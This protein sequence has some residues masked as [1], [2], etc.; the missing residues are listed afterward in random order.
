[1]SKIKESLQKDLATF[2]T[3]DKTEKLHF[4]WD[5][6]KIPLFVIG[7]LLLILVTQLVYSMGKG[8][9]AV[10]V[11]LVNANDVESDLFDR[12][13]EAETDLNMKQYR[14]DVTTSYQFYPE[15]DLAAEVNRTTIEVL[16]TSF[17]IGDLDV[18]AGSQDL[19]DRYA[20]MNAFVDLRLLIDHDLLESREEDIYYY[21]N[22]NGDTIAAGVWLREG[23]GIREAGYYSEDVLISVASNAA[24]LD[25][26]LAIVR[27]V[28]KEEP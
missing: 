3:L 23:S 13:L 27:S 8:K 19:I 4:I 7:M 1:M 2:K 16:G 15:E 22:D 25:N 17:A 6:Y 12:Y 20:A 26:A 14:A 9:D 28:L 21:T 11:I 10:Y 5:Y 18:L 24:N